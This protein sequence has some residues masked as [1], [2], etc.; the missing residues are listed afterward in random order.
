MYVV[1]EIELS[2]LLTTLRSPLQLAAQIGSLDIC[3]L[4]LE[5]GASGSHTDA[6][7]WTAA[8]YLWSK[9][10]VQMPDQTSFLN[11]LTMNNDCELDVVGCYNCTAL[12]RAAAFG[13]LAD[14]FT[15]V[16]NGATALLYTE[17]LEWGPIH[18]AAY[19]GNDAVLC[20]LAKP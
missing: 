16:R 20:E 10:N 6:R 19:F 18:Y 11:L 1:M 5:S 14:I 13:T 3:R 2:Y 15:L 12:H 8:F 9:C 4:L 7:G 17:G